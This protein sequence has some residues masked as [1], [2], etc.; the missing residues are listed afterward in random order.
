MGLRLAGDPL[1]GARA[2][3]L[4]S[5]GVLPGSIQVPADGRP[6]VLLADCQPTG[7]YPVV[8]VVIRADRA[9]LGQLVPGEAVAF[10]V[11]DLA[12]GAPRGGGA[13]E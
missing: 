10:R 5:L 12:G 9:A 6:I 2:M 4:A 13:A 11:V 7:G 1:P 8:A 3:E